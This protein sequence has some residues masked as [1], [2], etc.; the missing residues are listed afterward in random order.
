MLRLC[1]ENP[2]SYLG[3]SVQQAITQAFVQASSRHLAEQKS[4]HPGP[5]VGLGEQTKQ[6]NNSQ[7]EGVVVS[8]GNC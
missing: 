4:R 3:R 2:R 1:R 7:S 8:N 6:R 5:A